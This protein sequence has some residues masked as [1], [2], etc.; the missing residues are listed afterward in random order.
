MA[1]ALEFERADKL[2][3]RGE[4]VEEQARKVIA[5]I[6]E[7]VGFEG[8]KA[9]KAGEFLREWLR[10]KTSVCSAGTAERYRGVVEEFNR[11]LGD[12]ADRPV[13]AITAQHL[14]AFVTMRLEGG[15]SATTVNLEGKI[16]RGAFNAARRQGLIQ[17]N[18][19]EAVELPANDSVERGTFT[20]AEVRMLI[21]A[22]EDEWKTLIMLAY[23]T[24]ARLSDCCRLQWENVDLAASTLAFRPEKTRSKLKEVLIP[25]HPDLAAHLE[26]LA[27][28]DT[29]EKHLMP[30]MAGMGPG[31]RHGLSEGFKR[32][33][34]KAGL[35]LQTVQGSGM[36]KFSRRTF[37]ALR[38]SF[39]SALAN[40]G[41]AP[42]LRMKLTGHKS[43]ETHRGYT[44]HELSTLRDAVNRLPSLT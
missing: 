40:A 12:K 22:A 29:T 30:G 25:L 43:A 5:G 44:H 34:R 2:A 20:L 27:S 14:Q 37:H 41:V 17:N 31:G 19:A 23:Y 18:P 6:M 28:S 26:K 10:L 33:V 38:H 13:N 42:E 16:L 35:D 21:E 9:Q 3:G 4:L 11:F 24:G 39:T 15:R 7:R 32:I 1:V 36:R 8:I